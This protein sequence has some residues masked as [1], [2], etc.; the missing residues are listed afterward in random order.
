M[1]AEVN[2]RYPDGVRCGSIRPSA[3]RNR[4]LEIVTSEN[5]G[6][7]L[8][9]TSPMLRYALAGIVEDRWLAV[10]LMRHPRRSGTAGDTCRSAPRHH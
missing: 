3:S 5:S 4:I 6:R 10:W 9:S 1:S 7:S 2:F 8:A